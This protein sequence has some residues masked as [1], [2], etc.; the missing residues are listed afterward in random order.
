MTSGQHGCHQ[1][2]P[3]ANVRTHPLMPRLPL[4]SGQKSTGDA[5]QSRGY[6]GHNFPLSTLTD[7]VQAHRDSL[8]PG[9]AKLM[10]ESA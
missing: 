6:F 3:A 4:D 1:P 8:T 10:S 2:P 7:F 9:E 5:V